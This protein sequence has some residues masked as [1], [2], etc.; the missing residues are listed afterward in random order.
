MKRGDLREFDQ[1]RKM[2]IE[3]GFIKYAEGSCLIEMGNTRIIITAT[4][5]EKIPLFLRGRSRGWITAEYRMLPRATQSRRPR[6]R[7]SGRS[8]EIQRLIGRS[9]RSVIELKALGEKTIWVDCDVI[10]ADG[11]TRMASVV[12]GFVALVD[13]L[14][15]L[16]KQA[17]IMS[18]P[19]KG[20]L[21]AIS[22]GIVRGKHL[23]DLT[24]D[25]DSDADVDMNVVMKD[26]G[27]LVELQGAAEGSDFSREDLDQLLDLAHKG[28]EEIIDNERNIL[29]DV[30]F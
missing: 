14:G 4:V 12:G 30:M 1:L 21:G 6:D 23:L 17:R 16:Y 7:I 10:Q 9:L 27:R 22:V 11:G 25:E 28:I 5:E 29:K 24:Y 26:N 18:L 13:C 19:V 3:R 20:F 8:M 2:K 15:K